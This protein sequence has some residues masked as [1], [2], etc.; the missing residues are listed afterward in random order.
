MGWQYL[1]VDLSTLSP[2]G[3]EID[4]LNKAGADGWELIVIRP[5]ARALFKRPT[6]RER[7][8]C[9]THDLHSTQNWSSTSS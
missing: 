1:E 4:L 6:G 5:P 3:D 7:Y 9:Q 2:R 8:R